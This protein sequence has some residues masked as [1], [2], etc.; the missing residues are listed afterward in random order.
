MA[1]Y[2]IKVAGVRIDKATGK[3]VKKPSYAN[4]SDQLKRQSSKKSKPVRRTPGT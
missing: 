1:G 4:V 3:I 2:K